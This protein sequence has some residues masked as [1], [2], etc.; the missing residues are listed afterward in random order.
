ML[1]N[2]CTLEGDT[3]LILF[4]GSGSEV[5]VCMENSRNFITAELDKKYCDIIKNRINRKMR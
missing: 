5:E 3:A 2:S 4:G 1:I